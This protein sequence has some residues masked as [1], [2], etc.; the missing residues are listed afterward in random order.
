MSINRLTSSLHETGPFAFSRTGSSLPSK[1]VKTRPRAFAILKPGT[2]FVLKVISPSCAKGL[3]PFLWVYLF[4]G[5]LNQ[6]IGGAGSGREETE[7]GWNFGITTG[8]PSAGCDS[9]GT[10]SYSGVPPTCRIMDYHTSQ[11]RIESFRLPICKTSLLGDWTADQ[12]SYN[13]SDLR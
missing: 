1:P 8:A 12:G 5:T 2:L 6:P 9:T 4:C 11:R 3:T 13:R 10:S 7:A